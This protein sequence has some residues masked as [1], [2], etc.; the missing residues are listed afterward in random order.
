LG[1]LT[2]EYEI[3]LYHTLWPVGISFLGA[4]SP[5]WVLTTILPWQ[6]WK[7]YIILKMLKISPQKKFEEKFFLGE[8]Q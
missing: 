5:H 4:N 3:I 7:F 6:L 8:G 1:L 2:P